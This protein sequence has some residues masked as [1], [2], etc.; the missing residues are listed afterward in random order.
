MDDIKFYIQKELAGS[1]AFLQSARNDPRCQ[2]IV[3]IIARRAQGVWLWIFLVVRNLKKDLQSQESYNHLQRRI[4]EIPRTL[5]GYFRRMLSHIDPI[6]RIESARIILIMLQNEESMMTKFP[7]LGQPCLESELESDD[8]AVAEEAKEW[9][10]PDMLQNYEASFLRIEETAKIRIS[11]R[12]KD[13]VLVRKAEGSVRANTWGNP[14]V[15][16]YRYHLAFLH[17]TVRDFLWQTYY[18]VLVVDARDFSPA[19]SLSRLFLSLFK[20]HPISL[21]RDSNG[22][23]AFHPIFIQF[24]R[25]TMDQKILIEDKIINEFSRVCA[26][27]SY[28][29]WLAPLAKQI[30]L[31][32]DAFYEH[33]L[34][35]EELSVI[36]L[37]I[38]LGL[39]GYVRRNWNSNIVPRFEALG[40]SPLEL[41]FTTRPRWAIHFQ[42]NFKS[43]DIDTDV[44][45]VATLLD[46]GCDPNY[47]PLQLEQSVGEYILQTIFKHREK[48]GKGSLESLDI[49]YQTIKVLLGRKFKFSQHC[50]SGDERLG[51]L[52]QN[53]VEAKFIDL[54]GMAKTRE[55]MASCETL[56]P[57]VGSGECPIELLRL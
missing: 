3:D 13:L 27:R 8:Y 21:L 33:P 1:E 51:V 6:Y 11:D 25:L 47:T 7:L 9:S 24:W 37:A 12:C 46:L 52:T 10:S 53:I 55:L 54:F 39:S 35:D 28:G 2:E 19:R 15:S 17:R 5:D 29:P 34:L 56:P 22:V 38:L 40:L 16:I 48:H 14:E 45:T 44:D 50:P 26:S 30:T 20:R 57:A 43:E 18:D 31:S 4:D 49:L 36:S 23:T 42:P 32:T 41:A